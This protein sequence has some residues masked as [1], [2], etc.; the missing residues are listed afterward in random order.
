MEKVILQ[1]ANVAEQV[2]RY[3]TCLAMVV[4][5]INEGKKIKY[6]RD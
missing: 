2:V 5:F 4:L 3:G 1:I 6:G